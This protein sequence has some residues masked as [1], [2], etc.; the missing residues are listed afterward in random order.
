MV[1]SKKSNQAKTTENAGIV[2]T[3][4]DSKTTKTAQAI[5]IK[6]CKVILNFLPESNGKAIDA[7]KK[8]LVS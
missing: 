7:V 3:M 6:G 2:A 8:M 1:E 5:T 4:N